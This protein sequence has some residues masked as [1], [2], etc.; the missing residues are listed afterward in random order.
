MVDCATVLLAFSIVAPVTRLVV[1]DIGSIVVSVDGS[2][3]D[4]LLSDVVFSEL[5]TRGDVAEDCLVDLLV[6][7]WEKGNVK[8]RVKLLYWVVEIFVKSGNTEL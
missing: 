7:D 4:V 8:G 5:E 6:S 1:V 2:F 3:D